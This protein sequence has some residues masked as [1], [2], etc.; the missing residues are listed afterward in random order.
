MVDLKTRYLGLE[1]KNPL[2]LRPRPF[3]RKWM[4]FAVW[5]MP[6]LARLSCIRSLR[7]KLFTRAWPWIII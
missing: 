4:G 7:S 3:L 5:K 1:L 2:V 6:A